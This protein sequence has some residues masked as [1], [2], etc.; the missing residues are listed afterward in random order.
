MEQSNLDN[1][2]LIVTGHILPA[3]ERKQV[4]SNLERL[5]NKPVL[6]IDTLLN[7]SP[8][9]I[10]RNISHRKA[11]E[12]QTLL[13]DNGAEAKLQ[14]IIQRE[15]EADFSLVPY[16]EEQTPFTELQEKLKNKESIECPDC[17]AIQS[18]AAF[19]NQCGTALSVDAPANNPV[20][21]G[22]KI[23]FFLLVVSGVSLAVWFLSQN[24]L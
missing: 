3:F 19:C 10:R 2:N 12:M 7:G 23:L 11:F 1:Y 21:M 16:G 6:E 13:V 9:I 18:P 5:F 14:R 8:T 15:V 24:N 20:G 22:L 17:H 4:L